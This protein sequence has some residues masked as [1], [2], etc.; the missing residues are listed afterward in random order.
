MKVRDLVIRPCDLSDVKRFIET[1][2][3]SGSVNG[4]KT[5]ICYR[6]DYDNDLIGAVLYGQM[7]TTAWRRFGKS[8]S[9]VL[10]LRRL[11]LVDSAPKNSESRVIGWTLRHIRRNLNNVKT[12]V[13][14]ADP[15]HGHSGIIYKASN[16]KYIG[17]SARDTGFYN[18][19]TGKT[20]H[21][22]AL[23]TKYKGDYKPFVKELRFLRDIGILQP[24]VLPG[25]HCYVYSVRRSS[26]AKS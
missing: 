4:V 20:Y 25:K 14:Y 5:S 22:R 7:S 12:V 8:E 6:V 13:S 18:P 23:R 26:D 15:H 2:H 3:Y 1:H 16:F 21:S 17:V 11:V 19:N 10:E 9:E 24:I